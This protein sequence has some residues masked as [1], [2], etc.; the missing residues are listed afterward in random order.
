[1]YVF[2]AEQ[3]LTGDCSESVLDPVPDPGCPEGPKPPKA[4]ENPTVTTDAWGDLYVA[5]TVGESGRIDVFNAEGFYL[6]EVINPEVS[7]PGATGPMSIAVDS[8]GNLYVFEQGA[9]ENL[10]KRFP[11]TVYEPAKNKIEYKAPPVVVVDKATKPLV[12]LGFQSAIA[13]DA[14]DLLYVDGGKAISIFKSAKEGNELLKK[15]A[16]AGLTRSSSIA[17]DQAHSKIYISEKVPSSSVVRVF[18]RE[19]PYA[20]LKEDEIDGSTTPQG[21]FLTGESFIKVDVDEAT[22]HVFVGDLEAASKVYEFEEDGTYLATITHSFNASLFGEIRV[23]DGPLSPNPGY[24]YVPSVPSGLGHVYAFEPKIEGPPIVEE[25]SVS[26]VTET[27]AVLRALINPEGLPTEYRLEYVTQVGFEEGGFSEA[28]LAGEGS[29]PGGGEGVPVSATVTGLVPDTSYRFRATANNKLGSDEAEGHFRTFEAEAKVQPCPNDPLRLGASAGLPDC[30][31]YE[32]VTP[33]NTNGRPPTGTG[34]SGV[35]FPTLEAAPDGNRLSFYVEGGALPGQEAAGAFNGDP[36]LATRGATGWS[37]EVTG[38]SGKEATGPNPGSV[39]PD[40]TYSFW[41]DAK[42]ETV[43]IRYPDGHFELVGIGSLGEDPHVQ[44]KLI[45][46]NGGH[47]VFASAVQLEPDAAPAGTAA[48]YDRSAEG[49]TRVV[50][51]LPGNV[52]P[53]AGQAAKYLGASEDGEGIA[54]SIAGTI[55]LR[56]HNEESFEVAGPGAEFA[57]VADE[58]N[59]VF[60]VE[61]GDLFAFDAPGEETIAFSESGDITPANVASNGTRAYFVS[62]S[63]LTEEP[64]PNGENAE[65]GNENLYLSEEGQIGFVAQV[66]KRDVEGELRVDG[67]VGGLG[68]WTNALKESRPASD[69]SRATPSGSTFLFESRADLAGFESEGFVQVYRYDQVQNRLSCLSCSPTGTAPTSDASL[70]SIAEQL[71]SFA[72]MTSFARV[73]NQSPDGRRAFFQT[74]E[75]LVMRDT[76]EQLDVYEWEDEGVGSC[77]KPGGCV[78]LVSSGHSASPDFLYAMSQS[79]ND[80]F[81]RT[82]D[83]LLSRDAESTLSIYDARVDSGFP[84]PLPPEPCEEGEV[85]KHTPTPPPALP[86]PAKAGEEP[87]A[88]PAKVC[89]KGKRKVKR[90][91]QEVCVKKHQRQHKHHRRTGSDKKESA[92]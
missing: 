84:E 77:E 27:E 55:Y 19:V 66:T 5:S 74:A 6:S 67:L 4:F 73:P 9:K 61:G 57:G 12:S 83:I 28:A 69:P 8:E 7:G 62:P 91:G 37:S 65:A 25:V 20:E 49:P 58:G 64:N 3:S 59:R 32:L 33:G 38:P 54:F 46:E 88:P 11:P 63:N 89:P 15:E 60:Y 56:L 17:V 23:D 71:G 35:Y 29:L 51:L 31:A 1:V 81:F 90:H 14:S 41:E 76:D 70:Q 26:G 13:V 2:N 21:E 79:G 22:G 43:H 53:G 18:E 80:V 42:T 47:I 50:S 30:R 78:Y 34:F 39:S 44:A 16:I 10:I 75:P 72:P 86:T 24:L 52:T 87:P 68:L 92:K 82:S 40:Q 48:V 45:T 36:Y 85:C